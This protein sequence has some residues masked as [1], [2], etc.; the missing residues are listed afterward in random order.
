MNI[1]YGWFIFCNPPHKLLCVG[2]YER[3]FGLKQ[4]MIL[5]TLTNDNPIARKAGERVFSVACQAKVASGNPLLKQWI[6]GRF[7]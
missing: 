5:T 2:T 7:V 1:D 6:Q 3:K 4:P